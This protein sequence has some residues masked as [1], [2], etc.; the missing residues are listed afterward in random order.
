MAKVIK[1]A[2]GWATSEEGAHRLESRPSHRVISGTKA[3][4]QAEAEALLRRAREESESILAAAHEQVQ[5]LR[6]QAF[7]EAK[8]QGYHEGKE[9]GSQEA[10]AAVAAL[11]ARAERLEAE[12]VPQLQTLALAIARKILGRELER[13][14]DGVVDLVR[15]ALAEKARQRREIALRV[16][17]ADLEA[18]RQQRETLVE[19]LTRCK[20]VSVQE[21]PNVDRFGVVIETEAGTIDAQLESQLAVFESV[22][23][24]LRG[25]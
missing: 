6:Q 9:Q 16:H 2:S 22:F 3:A 24:E 4:A 23:K 10:Q 15:Q 13:S 20:E 14:P 19:V 12:V 8:D 25:S 5:T 1:S 17:P 11:V 21:D 7:D 18:V